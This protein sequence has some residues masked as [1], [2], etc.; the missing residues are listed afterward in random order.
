[1]SDTSIITPE[2][3]QQVQ[4]VPTTIPNLL[5]ADVSPVV[6]PQ[7]YTNVPLIVRLDLS[8]SCVSKKTFEV[9]SLLKD[10]VLGK[11]NFRVQNI[12]VDV[13][14][15]E[16]GGELAVVFH[17]MNEGPDDVHE[18]WFY[19]NRVSIM[20][21]QSNVGVP[22]SNEVQ[23]PPGVSAQIF[24]P[25]N[26]YSPMYITICALNFVGRVRL[27]FTVSFTKLLYT[28]DISENFRV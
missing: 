27:N 6:V 17:S 13:V 21:N 3:A 26:D 14:A 24:P 19:P 25:P 5:V 4:V 8:K 11:G 2:N 1:M 28:L 16:R 15:L 12:V 18:A 9:C 22:L 7:K 20:P 10:I 23:L